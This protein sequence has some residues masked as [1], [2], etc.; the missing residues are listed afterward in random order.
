[1]WPIRSVLFVPA[2]RRDWVAKAIHVSPGA[3]ILDIEDS[4]PWLAA[5]LEAGALVP[6]DSAG[7][8]AAAS[9]AAAGCDPPPCGLLPAPE[10]VGEKGCADLAAR[11]ILNPALVPV[12]ADAAAP[13]LAAGGGGASRC[14][15][16]ACDVAAGVSSAGT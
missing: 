4:V 10:P 1:M 6:S 5:A 2:H 13:V 15:A 3:V 14:A 7:A 8:G 12:S 11:F 9:A 16:S